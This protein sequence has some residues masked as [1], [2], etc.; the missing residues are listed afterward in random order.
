MEA[1]GT[2]LVRS[3]GSLEE[4]LALVGKMGFHLVELGIQSWCDLRPQNLV[5]DYE[6]ESA[7][8]KA[9]LRKYDLTPVAFNAG[10]GDNGLEEAAAIA[11]LAS[12]LS[13]R[14][15]TINPGSAEAD[16][17]Q[18]VERLR[19]LVGIFAARDVQ[20]SL[21]THMF[22]MTEQ[23]EDAL[24]LV[25]EVEGLGLT[26]DV[27]H[28]YCNGSEN[29]TGPLMPYVRHVHIR[30]CGRTWERI[31]M[32]YGEGLLELERW[33]NG[34]RDAGYEGRVAVEYIDLPNVAFSVEEASVRCKTA[35]ESVWGGANH[36]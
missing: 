30:D 5:S 2:T 9:L 29:R 21:E 26:L 34:L 13:V 11:A 8:L 36:D 14:V 15:V 12:E 6:R 17:E 16:F 24:K 27:S 18:E 4:A 1:V 31:Q 35:I 19:K 22:S 20:A 32:P 33:R 25:R 7:R 28:Y 3:A 10:L 23:P